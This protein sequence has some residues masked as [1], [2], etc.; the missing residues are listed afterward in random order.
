MK[1]RKRLVGLAVASTAAFGLMAAPAAAQ[2][3]VTGGLVNVNISDIDLALLNHLDIDVAAQVAVPIGIAANVCP[4][5]NAAVL[6]QDL[7]QDGEAECD[8]E[9]V[10]DSR[11]FLRYISR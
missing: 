11:Q 2:P 4:T 8:A 9:N 3:V 1:L 10:T 7:V 5:V 6:A